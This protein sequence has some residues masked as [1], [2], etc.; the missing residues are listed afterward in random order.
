MCA[1]EGSTG[2]IGIKS[3]WA[4]QRTGKAFKNGNLVFFPV[5]FSRDN[6]N[7]LWTLN[8]VLL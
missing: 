8:R 7:F 6:Q 2:Y 3:G 4:H 5:D 1:S